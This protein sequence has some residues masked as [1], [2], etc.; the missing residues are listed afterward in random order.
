M[1]VRALDT[2]ST[3]VVD[4]WLLPDS[5]VAGAPRGRTDISRTDVVGASTAVVGRRSSELGGL[6]TLLLIHSSSWVFPGVTAVE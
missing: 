4:V 5:V 1:S 2:T 6:L 3:A